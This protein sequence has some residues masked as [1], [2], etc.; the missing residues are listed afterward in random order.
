MR[1]RYFFTIALTALFLFPGIVFDIP[2]AL[3]QAP[4]TLPAGNFTFT[5][6]GVSPYALTSVALGSFIPGLSTGISSRISGSALFGASL[7]PAMPFTY[8]FGGLGLSTAGTF[9]YGHGLSMPP[10]GLGYTYPWGRVVSKPSTDQ[11]HD[12][13]GQFNFKVEIEG[14]TA[15]RF[16]GVDG[17]DSKTEVIEYQDGDDLILK[18]RPGS[19]EFKNFTLTEGIV[20]ITSPRD[21][22]GETAKDYFS[23]WHQGI[24]DGDITLKKGYVNLYNEAG[25]EVLRYTLYGAWP[26]KVRSVS[27][28][29]KGNDILTGTGGDEIA[30]EEVTLVYQKA[31]VEI[32]KFNTRNLPYAGNNCEVIV[33]G[34][35]VAVFEDAVINTE[36]EVEV[37]R[38][39]GDDLAADAPTYTDAEGNEQILRKRPGRV[40]YSNIILK[41]GY[42][43][44][45]VLWEWYKGITG[46]AMDGFKK[47]V[48]MVVSKPGNTA[49]V[50]R[51]N[52]FE[53]WPCKWKGW[54]LDGKG[55]DAVV[56]EIE[57]AVEEITRSK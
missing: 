45:G 55:T 11:P 47:S 21:G 9:Q 40:K 13:I 23:Q 12:H 8:T 30:I 41:R 31:D 18:K 2:L 42:L 3:G 24:L 48:T 15:G 50:A 37:V 10:Y 38:Y 5:G 7:G 53:A 46:G 28:D 54:D 16:K 29:G 49:P 17:L 26:S 52:F 14:V 57:L 43:D 6:Q 34:E 27:L 19:V 39:E 4:Y 25:A 56:E 35:R 1:S 20:P 32:K 44:S 22:D 51:Y 33:D 36:L